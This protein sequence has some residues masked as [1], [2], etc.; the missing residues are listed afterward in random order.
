MFDIVASGN[1]CNNLLNLLDNEN[2]IGI[3]PSNNSLHG[4]SLSQQAAAVKNFVFLIKCTSNANNPNK[5][6]NDIDAIYAD[7]INQARICININNLFLP[8]GGNSKSI[9]GKVIISHLGFTKVAIVYYTLKNN[10]HPVEYRMKI[11]EEKS[12]WGIDYTFYYRQY[13][14]QNLDNPSEKCLMFIA[15][16]E[17]D[18]NQFIYFYTYPSF[19]EPS[20]QYLPERGEC[21]FQVAMIN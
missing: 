10:P 21:I 11:I 15:S 9:S 5:T 3:L 6:S 1:A 17:K 8:E 13:I 20:K 12:S 2:L 16:S 19:F 14:V 7:L 4:K 18:K